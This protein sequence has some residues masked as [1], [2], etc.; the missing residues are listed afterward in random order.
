MKK[1]ILILV[2]MA[3]GIMAQSGQEVLRKVQNKFRSIQNFTA[4]FVQTIN[5]NNGIKPNTLKG[6][7]YYKRKNKFVVELN[8]QTITSDG[9]V[10]WNYDVRF[11]RVVINNIENDPTSFSL[12]KFIFDYPQHCNVKVVKNGP[13]QKGEKQ[14]E[15]DPND[16]SMQFKWAKI[17]VQPDGLIAKMEVQDRGDIKYILEF[18]DLKLNQNLADQKFTFY[19]P[20]GTKII[21]LR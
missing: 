12:E 15:L 16:Q 5:S 18:S 20:K 21:D 4:G 14:I 19:P 13:L 8:N 2:L 3:S 1:I 7:F 11:K 10:I 6:T 17:W 9:K